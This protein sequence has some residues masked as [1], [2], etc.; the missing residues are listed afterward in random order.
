[1]TLSWCLFIL[2]QLGIYLEAT[3]LIVWWNYLDRFIDEAFTYG[4]YTGD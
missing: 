3:V 1:M 4:D 2:K